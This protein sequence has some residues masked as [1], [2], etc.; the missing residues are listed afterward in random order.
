MQ[1]ISILK[2]V[3]ALDFLNKWLNIRCI[4]SAGIPNFRPGEMKT[5]LG[6]QVGH[7]PS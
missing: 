2:E 1:L 4:S 7:R 5:M 3:R 6:Q